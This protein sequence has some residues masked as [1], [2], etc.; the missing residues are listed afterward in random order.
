MSLDLGLRLLVVK[1]SKDTWHMGR[2]CI[3]TVQRASSVIS[4]SG[5]IV[6]SRGCLETTFGH[7]LSFQSTDGP[8]LAG[9]DTL[10]FTQMSKW[11]SQFPHRLHSGRDVG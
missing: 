3:H 10:L 9:A 1:G 6:S 5:R 7:F 4:M 2:V 11:G 8:F